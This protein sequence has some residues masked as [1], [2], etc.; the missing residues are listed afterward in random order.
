MARERITDPTLPNL[1]DARPNH[2]Y[3]P[4]QHPLY[5]Y[6]YNQDGSINVRTIFAG[7]GDGIGA[8]G[9][10][11]ETLAAAAEAVRVAR[12][13]TISKWNIHSWPYEV[14]N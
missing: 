14:I 4:G 3:G 13:R 6:S 10:R 12:A 1:L 2:V 9:K 7:M 8:S 11:F 5:V